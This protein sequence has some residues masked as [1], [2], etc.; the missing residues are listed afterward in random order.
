MNQLPDVTN[1]DE[2]LL[3]IGHLNMLQAELVTLGQPMNDLELI[4]THVNKYSTV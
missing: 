1:F 3:S 2:D 4:I